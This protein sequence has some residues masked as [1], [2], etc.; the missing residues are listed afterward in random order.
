[1]ARLGYFP[2]KFFYN[3]YHEIANIG[4]PFYQIIR[5]P[6]NKLV[7]SLFIDPFIL[8]LIGFVFRKQE[9]DTYIRQVRE[10]CSDILRIY[11]VGNFLFDNCCN[12]HTGEFF[13]KVR[14]RPIVFL[15]SLP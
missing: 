6:D 3:R 10:L 8:V 12:F 9:C 7:S 11:F 2:Q 5:Q 13:S 4:R 14:T 15:Q 1:M